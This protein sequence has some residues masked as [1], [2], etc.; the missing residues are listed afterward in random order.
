MVGVEVGDG[1]G[2]GVSVGEGARVEGDPEQPPKKR[3]KSDR[4]RIR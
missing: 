2:E 1:L 4:Q 3:V